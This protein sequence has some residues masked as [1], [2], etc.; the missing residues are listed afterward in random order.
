M[1][2][3]LLHKRQ[4]IF[5]YTKYIQENMFTDIKIFCLKNPQFGSTIFD[6]TPPTMLT[7]AF[8]SLK[9]NIN[10]HCGIYS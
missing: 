9:K 7:K 1:L 4:K 8:F 6:S 3:K 2:S 5:F 10:C